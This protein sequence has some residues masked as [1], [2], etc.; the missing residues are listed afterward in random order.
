[1]TKTTPPSDQTGLGPGPAYELVELRN[2]AHGIRSLAY[3]EICHPGVGPRAEAEALYVQGLDLPRRLACHPA[4]TPFV[5]W[6]IGLGGAANATAVIQSATPHRVALQVL[7][8][9]RTLGQLAFALEHA[10]VLGYWD[11][12]LPVGT[13]LLREGR[14]VFRH[15]HAEVRWTCVLGDFTR[16]VAGPE[17]VDSPAP[18]AIVFDPHSPAAN[19]EMWTL[20]FFRDLRARLDPGRAC[21]LA[22]YSRG[23]SVRAALLLAGF[24]V[25]TGRGTATK[26][27]TT[28]AANEPGLAGSLLGPRWFERALRSTAAEPWTLPPYASQPLTAATA[29]LLRNHPQ[30]RAHA[31][32]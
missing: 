16:W 10:A 32:A 23:T 6:D 18:H 14:V 1:M 25:G 21:N 15:G 28:L 2:G 3:G 5:V 17:A 20:P 8:F 29:A 26:E 30:L 11:G 12:L 13:Q 4:G 24:H 22:T 27:E 31:P 7:S 9:D 19:P